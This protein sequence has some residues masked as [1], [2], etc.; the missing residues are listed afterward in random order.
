MKKHRN[1]GGILIIRF[2]A[3]GDSLVSIPFVKAVSDIWPDEK[4]YIAASRRGADAFDGLPFI[5]GVMECDPSSPSEINELAVR[6]AGMMFSKAFILSEKIY[7]YNLAFKAG[8]PVR[9]GF[10]PGMSKPFKSIM[11][12]WLLTHR[13]F[14]EVPRTGGSL[15]ETERQ[16]LLLKAMGHDAEPCGYSISIPECLE[17]FAGSKLP[18]GRRIAVH[19]SNKWL[20]CGW[21]FDFL[22][23]LLKGLISLGAAVFATYGEAERNIADRL[24]E[25]MPELTLLGGLSFKEWAALLASSSAVVTMD[26]SASHV[27][28]GLS[29]TSVVVF[30]E[31]YFRH[32]L[33]RWHPWRSE[34]K[35]FAR[36]NIL[37]FSEN[38]RKKEEG[39]LVSVISEAV[40][41]LLV[42]SEKND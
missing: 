30:E 26:T 19:L 10:D 36:K 22:E 4:I 32:T 6:A 33:D 9:C 12:R 21:S 20:N 28:A 2:D 29:V 23:K 7:A 1:D 3:L 42:G 24:S 18:S 39:E 40:A 17:G 25:S 35:A 5:D 27:A 41:A 37:N 8:I 11:C 15:H 16:F 31:E 13:A 38:E 34:F 14:C